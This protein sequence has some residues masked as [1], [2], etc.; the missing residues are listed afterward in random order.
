[1][2]LKIFESGNIIRIVKES[3]KSIENGIKM[4]KLDMVV[5]IGARVGEEISWGGS[6]GI[7]IRRLGTCWWPSRVQTFGRMQRLGLLVAEGWAGGY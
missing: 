5:I 3:K 7:G 6:Y 1:M 2:E 4:E